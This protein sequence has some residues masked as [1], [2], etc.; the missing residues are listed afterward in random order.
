MKKIVPDP[1]STP[2]IPFEPP[3]LALQSPLG[4]NECHSMLHTLSLIMHETVNVFLDSQPG[5]ARDAMGMNIRLL[6]RFMTVLHDQTMT[7]GA[8]P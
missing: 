8:K 1:P 4:I 3:P 2:L 6:C 7:E 5:R